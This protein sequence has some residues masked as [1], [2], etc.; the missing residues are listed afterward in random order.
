MESIYS[1]SMRGD[2][3]SRLSEGNKW[4]YF[5]GVSAG[6]RINEESFMADS[7]FDELKSRLSYG[8]VGNTAISP[9]N[10]RWF[11]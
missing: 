6:W 4:A 11:S 2:G 1:V 7:P 3:S 9:I 8:E 10:S 5:P